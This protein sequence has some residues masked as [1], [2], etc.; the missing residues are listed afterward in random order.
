MLDASSSSRHDADCSGFGLVLRAAD[1][2][3]DGNNQH[4]H[5]H[6]HHHRPL[7]VSRVI[8]DS[9]A[10]RFVLVNIILICFHAHKVRGTRNFF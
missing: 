2:A 1:A 8:P 4:H 6:H 7:I 5:R 3:D 10:D 9:P